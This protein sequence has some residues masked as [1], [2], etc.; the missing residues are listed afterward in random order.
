M[1]SNCSCT[2]AQLSPGIDGA[3]CVGQGQG[4]SLFLCVGLQNGF[5]GSGLSLLGLLEQR[6]LRLGSS[7][8]VKFISHISGGWYGRVNNV[9]P[10]IYSVTYSRWLMRETGD[11]SSH[12]NGFA[13]LHVCKVCV[14][15]S[16]GSGCGHMGFCLA[17][18]YLPRGRID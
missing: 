13:E 12:R 9:P 14:S 11:L 18:R 3:A 10:Q 2:D 6:H 7:S 5:L 8:Q 15:S 1:G 17:S 4:R 16:V